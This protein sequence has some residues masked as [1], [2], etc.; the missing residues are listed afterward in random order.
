MDC[1]FRVNPLGETL[2]RMDS[3][4]TTIL[5]QNGATGMKFRPGNPKIAAVEGQKGMK[6]AKGLKML[7]LSFSPSNASCAQER[8]QAELSMS[9]VFVILVVTF[10]EMM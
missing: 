6:G 7:L 8:R 4:I 3:Q 5:V 2:G 10:S 1:S 9:G